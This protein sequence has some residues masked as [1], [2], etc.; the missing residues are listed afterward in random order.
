VSSSISVR[1][2]KR[3]P[4]TELNFDPT[5]QEAGALGSDQRASERRTGIYLS[6]SRSG[7]VEPEYKMTIFSTPSGL[8]PIP[9]DLS[10]PEFML[11]FASSYRPR[12]PLS[13]PW[14]IDD[15]T[16]RRFDYN[17]VNARVQ[18]LANGL[19]NVCNLGPSSHLQPPYRLF[20]SFTS[21]GRRWHVISFHAL[22]FGCSPVPQSV[23]S[24]QTTL[25]ILYP[26]GPYI[27]LAPS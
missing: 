9:D 17:Q 23:S 16:G 12:R 10:V 20:L 15:A 7:S 5:R 26:F 1:Q 19:K 13:A 25:T 3:W 21:R 14:L 6:S 18:S 22:V 11:D 2:F 24:V 8:P 4:G 27:G